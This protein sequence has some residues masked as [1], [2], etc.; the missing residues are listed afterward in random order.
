MMWRSA[1][2]F[3]SSRL[4]L[5][6][7]TPLSTLTSMSSSLTP[8]R[9]NLNTTSPSRR[10][11]STGSAALAELDQLDQPKA[12]WV[13]LSNSCIKGSKDVKSTEAHLHVTLLGP[14]GVNPGF[15]Y[16]LMEVTSNFTCIFPL[17]REFSRSLCRTDA[18]GRHLVASAGSV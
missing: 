3:S 18:A 16:L 10:M 2:A 14:H 8:G 17:A 6:V 7:S 5:T 1:S 11:P 15:S 9:S 12:C 13:S 4:A